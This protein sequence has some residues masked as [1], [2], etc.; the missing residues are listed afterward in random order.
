VDGE[1]MTLWIATATTTHLTSFAVLLGASSQGV[2][3]GNNVIWVL[4]VSFLA[5]AIGKK[6]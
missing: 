2:L 4:S 3:C 1:E 6:P 5:A